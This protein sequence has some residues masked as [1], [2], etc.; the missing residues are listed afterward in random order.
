[1]KKKKTKG[2]KTKVSGDLS[3]NSVVALCWVQD[4]RQRFCHAAC[5]LL[6]K[7]AT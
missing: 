1:M 3:S 5:F 2:S 7:T 6:C 4:F